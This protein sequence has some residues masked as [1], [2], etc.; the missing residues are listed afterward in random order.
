[1]ETF[2][3]LENVPPFCF[4]LEIKEGRVMDWIPFGKRFGS[5]DLIT[6]HTESLEDGN[7]IV[8]YAL[9]GD[10]EEYHKNSHP[11][12]F[13]TEALLLDPKGESLGVKAYNWRKQKNGTWRKE[14]LRGEEK[15]RR[16]I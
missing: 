1:M 3:S 14:S 7:T 4:L 10:H 16:K 12:L 13:M 5:Q 6:K 2:V 8:S 15:K 9:S 11:E